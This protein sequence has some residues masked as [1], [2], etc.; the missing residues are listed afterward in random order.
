MIIYRESE[1]GCLPANDFAKLSYLEHLI[2]IITEEIVLICGQ[3]VMG[4]T[5]KDWLLTPIHILAIA[6]TPIRAKIELDDIKK[7]A[8]QSSWGCLT[9]YSNV[10]IYWRDVSDFETQPDTQRVY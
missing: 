6:I 1:F 8:K 7:E 2:N 10:T 4:M 3:D 9:T 5:T